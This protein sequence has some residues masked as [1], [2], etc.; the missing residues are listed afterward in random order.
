MAGMK[1]LAVFA[2][3]GVLP[4]GIDIPAPP[5]PVA[6]RPVGPLI[7]PAAD[8]L[9]VE[10]TPLLERHL[11]RTD[12]FVVSGEETFVSGTLDLAGDGYLAVTPPG[13]APKLIKIS[14][15]MS[16]WWASGGRYYSASLSVNI[17]RARLNNVIVIRDDRD[18]VVWQKTIRELFRLTYASG[19][20]VT[21]AGRP[22]RL[23]YANQPGGSG[24]QGLCFIY[25]ENRGG[26]HEYH[27]FL[28]PRE[29]IESPFP[30]S[31]RMYGGDHIRLRLDP[32]GPRLHIAR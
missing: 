26:T 27:F 20:P 32:D 18:R 23:F 11:T 17:F 25:D 6:G 15:G 10:L 22:Y 29:Q 7:L 21:L 30:T 28:V 24:R 13:G 12:R 31:Y 3:L 14:R 16:G 5:L 2:A 19:E 1:E 4:P 9:T 8:T